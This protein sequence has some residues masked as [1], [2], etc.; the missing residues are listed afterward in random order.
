MGVIG[1]TSVVITVV[2]LHR[3]HGPSWKAQTNFVQILLQPE[4]RTER[5]SQAAAVCSI[6]R[7]LRGSSMEVC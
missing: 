1:V 5:K 3:E 7:L 4:A 6:A 2:H